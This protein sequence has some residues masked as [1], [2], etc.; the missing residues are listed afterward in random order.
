M[1]KKSLLMYLLI[2]AI[3]LVGSMKAGLA[4]AIVELMLQ[5][6]KKKLKKSG[7]LGFVLA[8]GLSFFVP[9]LIKRV[10]ARGH[11]QKA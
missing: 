6:P 1:D 10:F 3:M 2:F 7:L 9:L 8:V 4:I 5:A 11:A